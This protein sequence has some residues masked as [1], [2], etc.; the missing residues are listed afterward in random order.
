MGYRTYLG[1]LDKPTFDLINGK[2]PKEVVEILDIHEEIKK[3]YSYEE[4]YLDRVYPYA[5]YDVLKDKGLFKEFYEMGAYTDFDI[6]KLNDLLNYNDSDTTFKLA[7]KEFFEYLISEYNKKTRKYYNDLFNKIKAY[8]DSDDELIKIY[9]KNSKEFYGHDSMRLFKIK[10]GF[11]N[12]SETVK[13]IFVEE[14]LT[15]FS[16][17]LFEWEDDMKHSHFKL[18]KSRPI[19]NSNKYEYAINELIRQYRAF[20]W[21]NYV[22]MYTGH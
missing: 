9:E 21:E 19:T 20:D 22:L 11:E 18:D 6:S 3:Y 2:K 13:T 8:K 14:M 15:H 17:M 10:K 12:K 4:N 16:D 1:R 5:I 7:N